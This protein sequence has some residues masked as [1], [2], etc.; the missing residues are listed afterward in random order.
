MEQKQ[1]STEQDPEAKEISE[2]TSS[3][4]GSS[5]LLALL[6]AH[7]A[8]N[9]EVG[10]RLFALSNGKIV[11]A[12]VI[13]ETYDSFLV[14]NPLFLIRN[15]ETGEVGGKRLLSGENARLMKSSI[16]AMSQPDTEHRYYYYKLLQELDLES[17]GLL[18]P[19]QLQAIREVVYDYESKQ[20]SQGATDSD[21]NEDEGPK[22]WPNPTSYSS[23][24]KH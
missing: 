10:D 15:K 3:F 11:F 5:G 7:P 17:S 8:K 22:L 12:L 21:E 13:A 23:R 18:S 9:N 16:V 2:E 19:I 6:A 14:F 24:V 4:L 1:Q 20:S